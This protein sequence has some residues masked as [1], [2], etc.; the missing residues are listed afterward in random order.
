MVPRGSNGAGQAIL[1][2]RAL[3]GRPAGETDVAAALTAYDEQRREATAAAVPAE[4]HQAA[5]RDPARGLRADRR[6]RPFNRIGRYGDV[7]GFSRQAMR[8]AATRPAPHSGAIG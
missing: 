5:R 7:A 2:T 3:A 8:A 1:D 4:P 6:D